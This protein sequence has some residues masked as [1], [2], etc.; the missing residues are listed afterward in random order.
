MKILLMALSLTLSIF[1]A[2]GVS[3]VEHPPGHGSAGRIGGNCSKP[4]LEKFS[5]PNMAQVTPGTEFS[6][7]IFNLDDPEQLE[8]TAKKIPV[9]VSTEFKDPFY[10]VTGKLPDNLRNTV[11][12]IN[13]KVNAKSN[14]CEAENGW[15]V[16]I[17][18]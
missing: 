12:R 14:A 4:K 11:A 6:L 16:K 2:T 15:L 10:V 3:A 18:E 1:N 8:V 5:P 9:E 13:V 7:H 17:S